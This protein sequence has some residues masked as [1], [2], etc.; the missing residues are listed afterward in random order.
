MIRIKFLCLDDS[1]HVFLFGYE[2]SL[3]P[4]EYKILRSLAEHGDLSADAL[5]KLCALSCGHC[6]VAVH[7]SAINAKAEQISERRLIVC[8]DSLYRINEMM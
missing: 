8:R 3:S 7:I 5:T 2:L 4:T 1:E 6:G